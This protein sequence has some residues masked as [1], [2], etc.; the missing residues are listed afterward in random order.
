MLCLQYHLYYSVSKVVFHRILDLK[1]AVFLY[2]LN[3][4]HVG[5]IPFNIYFFSFLFASKA[6]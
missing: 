1:R 2:G 5:F 3:F 6:M 4:F